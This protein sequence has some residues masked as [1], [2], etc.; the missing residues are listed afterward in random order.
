MAGTIRKPCSLCKWSIFEV[1]MSANKDTCG[2]CIRGSEF[3]L[4]TQAESTTPQNNTEVVGMSGLDDLD[5]TLGNCPTCS[6]TGKLTLSDDNDTTS[7]FACNG[8][9]KQFKGLHLSDP[10]IFCGIGH[11]DVG[12]GNCTFIPRKKCQS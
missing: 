1:W 8:S 6:G 7:C 10:C 4:K 2:L 9:G 12:I 11:D 3:V 5:K